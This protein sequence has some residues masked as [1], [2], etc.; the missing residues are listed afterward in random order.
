MPQPLLG[1][2]DIELLT[3]HLLLQNPRMTG[4]TMAFSVVVGIH[5]ALYKP[6]HIPG[7]LPS[8]A[9]LSGEEEIRKQVQKRRGLS[10]GH[11]ASDW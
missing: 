1:E 9:S 11:M 3:S 4:T 7:S 8:I 2:D 5:E 10:Q 6:S